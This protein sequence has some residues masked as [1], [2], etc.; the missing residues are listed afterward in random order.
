[1][2]VMPSAAQKKINDNLGFFLSAPKKDYRPRGRAFEAIHKIMEKMVEEREELI[3]SAHPTHTTVI[4]SEPTI[5]GALVKSIKDFL[6]NHLEIHVR[7]TKTDES[8]I[9]G[10]IRI[11]E[12]KYRGLENLPKKEE[13]DGKNAASPQKPLK[14]ETY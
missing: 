5:W 3:R 11:A 1:M 10:E 7:E 13:D 9:W 4:M 2:D 14:L 12:R 6:G 8:E